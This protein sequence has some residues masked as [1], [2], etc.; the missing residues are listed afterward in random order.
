MGCSASIPKVSFAPDTAGDDEAIFRAMPQVD[1]QHVKTSADP[2]G[3]SGQLEKFHFV[4]QEMSGEALEKMK[5][6]FAAA[7]KEFDRVRSE[8]VARATKK[9]ADQRAFF[10]KDL[11]DVGHDGGLVKGQVVAAMEELQAERS[12]PSAVA[13]VKAGWLLLLNP[14][15]GGRRRLWCLLCA[16]CDEYAQP[17]RLQKA[18]PVAPNSTGIMFLFSGQRANAPERTFRLWESSMAY[19]EQDQLMM[20]SGAALPCHLQA[21]HTAARRA[22]MAALYPYCL[23][24]TMDGPM[25]APSHGLGSGGEHPLHAHIAVSLYT[26]TDPHTSARPEFTENVGDDGEPWFEDES[27]YAV[28]L[29]NGN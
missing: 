15:K 8:R 17:R 19:A 28:G 9:L 20:A 13:L 12:R 27:Q 24:A 1:H 3:T 4:Q 23:H 26:D 6:Q 22:W 10:V 18:G 5:W 29:H 14:P 25:H 7:S 11:P 16:E 21:R 2:L